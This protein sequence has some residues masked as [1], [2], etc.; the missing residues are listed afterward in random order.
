MYSNGGPLSGN[1]GRVRFEKKHSQDGSVSS[2]ETG[3]TPLSLDLSRD[4][5]A[6]LYRI[7]AQRSRN[8]SGGSNLNPVPELPVE[9]KNEHCYYNVSESSSIESYNK[10]GF[11]H[12]P[13][14]TERANSS[15]TGSPPPAPPVLSPV[16][17]TNYHAL[18]SPETF[19]VTRTPPGGA[20][21]TAADQGAGSS[22]GPQSL[23]PGSSGGGADPASVPSEYDVPS[24]I[25]PYSRVSCLDFP[26]P[27]YDSSAGSQASTD[28]VID[29]FKN[30]K[31]A[32]PP[33][34]AVSAQPQPQTDDYVSEGFMRS[35]ASNTSLNE[36]EGSEIEPYSL[37]GEREETSDS[38]KDAY[39]DYDVDSDEA[40]PFVLD[41]SPNPPGLTAAAKNLAAGPSVAPAQTAAPKSLTNDDSAN[42]TF[43]DRD[44]DPLRVAQKS[45]EAMKLPPVSSHAHQNG[46]QSEDGYV[47]HPPSGPVFNPSKSH[48]PL[49]PGSSS[50]NPDSSSAFPGATTLANAPSANYVA[51]PASIPSSDNSG[52]PLGTN[53]TNSEYVTV[54]SLMGA[55]AV[56]PTDREEQE[57]DVTSEEG[58]DRG[59]GNIIVSSQNGGGYVHITC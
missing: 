14:V 39:V 36:S 26:P 52:R 6:D 43:H 45:H 9:D 3:T 35:M 21:E 28:T 18:S 53:G 11:E 17:G 13:K 54:D 25:S 30:K 12:D 2:M 20:G 41:S 34:P 29:T 4:N 40:Q 48:H 49:Q 32:S 50:S 10:V 5:E 19:P 44:R 23:A 15:D 1:F 51:P 33:P 57:E 47:A 46:S 8:V 58:N 31:P 42:S 38:K 24:M 22:A 27:D 16:E 7:G 59:G 56:A 55:T 37:L